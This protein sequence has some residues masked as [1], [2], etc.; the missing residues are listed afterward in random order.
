[1]LVE[2]L[3]ALAQA[4]GAAVVQAAGTNAWEAFR[5]RAATLLGRGDPQREQNELE[6]L[7][8]TATVLATAGDGD[9]LRQEESWRTRFEI[10]LESLSDAER[11]EFAEKLHVLVDYIRPPQTSGE[12]VSG[13]T[14]HGA[15]A[16]QVGN[17][18]EQRNHWGTGK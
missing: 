9:V 11:E 7:D 4:G 5:Q 13:N 16:V 6:R 10:M 14:F 8:R 18:N 2:A 17:N 15:T 3:E 12:F 1:V